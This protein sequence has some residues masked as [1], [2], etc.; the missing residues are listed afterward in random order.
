MPLDKELAEE[1][2]KG[3]SLTKVDEAELA[4]REEEKKKRAEE[5]EKVKKALEGQG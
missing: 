2:K 3:G 5:L 1:I 4:A